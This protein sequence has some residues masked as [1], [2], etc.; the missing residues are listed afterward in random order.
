MAAV[1]EVK[2]SRR[3]WEDAK[4]K[5]GE[6][7]FVGTSMADTGGPNPDTPS[8]FTPAGGSLESGL[9]GRRCISVQKDIETLPGLIRF[10]GRYAAFKA[11]A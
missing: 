4:M 7:L 1:G 2:G 3:E 6:M 5:Y 9:T 10:A 11:Y 8:F